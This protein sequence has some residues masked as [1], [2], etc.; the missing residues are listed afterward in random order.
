MAPCLVSLQCSI[1]TETGNF[2][3]VDGGQANAVSE[4]KHFF[5]N[6]GLEDEKTYSASDEERRQRGSPT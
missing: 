5:R 2:L 4:A 3:E 1:F 6:T